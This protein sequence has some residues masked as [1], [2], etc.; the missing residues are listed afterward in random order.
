[1][2]LLKTLNY[3][4]MSNVGLRENILISLYRLLND[5]Q[6]AAWIQNKMQ[7]MNNFERPV[8]KIA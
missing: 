5:I 2:H 6:C 8:F 7:E 1:M 3:Y 4:K